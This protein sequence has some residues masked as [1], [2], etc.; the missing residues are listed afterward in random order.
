MVAMVGSPALEAAMA[1]GALDMAATAT[2][3]AT[4]EEAV[5][6]CCRC[7]VQNCQALQPHDMKPCT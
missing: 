1:E 2:V 4:E 5:R 3:A 6:A 7:A